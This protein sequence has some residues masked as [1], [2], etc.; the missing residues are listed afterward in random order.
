[1]RR[2][3]TAPAAAASLLAAW[4]VVEAS[5]SRPL[6]GVVLLLCAALLAA[7]WRRRRG[8]IVAVQLLAAG[9]AAFIASHLIAL[10]T[11]AWPAVLVSALAFAWATWALADAPRSAAAT[12]TAR[13]GAR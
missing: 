13:R 2:A 3:P 4:A 11:G 6:G 8:T 9:L 7:E 1:M 12:R 5:G 10:A